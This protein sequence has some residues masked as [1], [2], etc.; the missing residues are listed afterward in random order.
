MA[1]SGRPSSSTVVIN[2]ARIEEM[3]QNSRWVTFSEISSELQLSFGS[4]HHIVCDVLRYSKTVLRKHPPRSGS[5][6]RDLISTKTGKTS[7]FYV[8]IKAYIDLR[9]PP[10]HH[11]YTAKSPGQSIQCRSSRAHRGCGSRV[12]WVSDRGLPCHEFEPSTTKR[13]TVRLTNKDLLR[14]SLK[15]SAA[16]RKTRGFSAYLQRLWHDLPQEVIGENIELITHHALFCIPARGGLTT[17]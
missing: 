6:D 9:N 3:I 4:V 5:I 2:T 15:A 10:A 1:G 13:P 17:Y 12:V 14:C 16:A 8:L 11:W 7:W